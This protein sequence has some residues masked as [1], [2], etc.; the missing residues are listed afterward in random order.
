MSVERNSEDCVAA[1]L[2]ART[3]EY[4]PFED[5]AETTVALLAELRGSEPLADAVLEVMARMIAN[6]AAR[7]LVGGSMGDSLVDAEGYL[8]LGLQHSAGL[9]GEPF[10]DV[11][12]R[13]A[14]PAAPFWQI[15]DRSAPPADLSTEPA[16]A[17]WLRLLRLLVAVRLA[18]HPADRYWRLQREARMIGIEA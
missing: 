3:A 10:D 15:I 18:L 16:M 7:I 9:A 14:A 13:D 8:R 2:A 12:R 4:G 6:K 17:D 1:V 11:I 5:V